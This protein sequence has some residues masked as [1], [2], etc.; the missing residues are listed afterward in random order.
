MVSWMAAN[1]SLRYLLHIL[2]YLHK[3]PSLQKFR[4]LIL[5]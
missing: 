5:R 4:E 3:I 1:A 2:L